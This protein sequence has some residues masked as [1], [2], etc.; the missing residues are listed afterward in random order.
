MAPPNTLPLAHVFQIKGVCEDC[1]RRTVWSR[2]RIARERLRRQ[3]ATPEELG[4]LFYCSGCRD[5]GG[6]GKNISIRVID[7]TGISTAIHIDR[8]PLSAIN[9]VVA[10]CPDCGHVLVFDRQELDDLSDVKSV[11][12]LW[13]GSYCAQCHEAGGRRKAM[14]L[15]V[16]PPAFDPRDEPKVKW[17]QA[18][19]FGENRSDPFPNLR[20]RFVTQES[21]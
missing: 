9:R 17:S 5:R 21:A 14:T 15:E 1:G 7:R 13:R 11:D 2:D 16:E 20:R 18:P 8:R 4:S 12:E 3:I 6:E 19:V 10:S